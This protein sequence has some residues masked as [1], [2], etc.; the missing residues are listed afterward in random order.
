MFV[1]GLHKHCTKQYKNSL[2][3][4]SDKIYINDLAFPWLAVCL[5]KNFNQSNKLLQIFKQK[6]HSNTCLYKSYKY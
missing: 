2:N 5:Y 3:Q 6:P 1:F 4:K